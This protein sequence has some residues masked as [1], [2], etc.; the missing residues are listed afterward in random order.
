VPN[1]KEAVEAKL[2]SYLVTVAEIEKLTGEKL[3]VMGDAR[4]TSPRGSWV[5]PIGCNKG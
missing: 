2:D 3:P 5:V 1:T 4:T